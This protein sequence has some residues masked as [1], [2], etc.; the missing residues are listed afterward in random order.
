MRVFEV[1]WLRSWVQ[2]CSI[3]P[4]FFSLIWKYLP[5]NAWLILLSYKQNDQNQAL[6]WKTFSFDDIHIFKKF[7]MVCCLRQLFN[8]Q[9][10]CYER[11]TIHMANINQLEIH[12]VFPQMWANVSLLCMDL[13][14]PQ[15]VFI[16]AV[17][18]ILN[19]ASIMTPSIEFTINY[20]QKLICYTWKKYCQL[21]VHQS[22][23]S[24]FMV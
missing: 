24:S 11:T 14:T 2:K 9:R 18:Y 22:T 4:L 21:N 19:L 5:L 20:F 16:S 3:I 13:L 7:A 10:S 23:E 8:L 15:T 1:S 12:P 6:A 17:L